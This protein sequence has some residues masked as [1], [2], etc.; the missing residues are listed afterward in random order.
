MSTTRKVVIVTAVTIAVVAVALVAISLVQTYGGTPIIIKGGSS[1]EPATSI[2]FSEDPGS[3]PSHPIEGEIA[4]IKLVGASGKCMVYHLWTWAWVDIQ[5]TTDPP[6][7]RISADDKDWS[8][9]KTVFD[10]SVFTAS[11]TRKF[12]SNQPSNITQLT[13]DPGAFASCTDKENNKMAEC[14]KEFPSPEWPATEL[15]GI[16]I[17]INPSAASCP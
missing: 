11:G 6:A 3:G 4:A 16:E 14:P 9:L 17:T 7:Y 12:V 15:S 5:V 13:I 2:T 8:D 10:N 1:A